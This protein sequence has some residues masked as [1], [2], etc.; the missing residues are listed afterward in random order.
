MITSA[1]PRLILSLLLLALGLAG[2]AVSSST[3]EDFA[4]LPSLAR[5]AGVYR[6]RG[7]VAN[8]CP[9]PVLLSYLLWPQDAQLRHEQVETIAVEALGPQTLRV[10]AQGRDGARKV[11]EY[12]LGRDFRWEGGRL[13]LDPRVSVAGFRSG[14]PMLGIV[15]EGLVLGLDHEGQGKVRQTGSATGMAFLVVPLHF[16]TTNDVRFAKLR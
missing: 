9:S 16:G 13:R 3:R 14:E 8:P 10:T 7:E 4:P 5:L 6:N 2:C 1:R 11:G 15:S 12:V